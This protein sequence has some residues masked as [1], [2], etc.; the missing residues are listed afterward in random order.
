VTRVIGA[1]RRHPIF[2]PRRGPK[3][4]SVDFSLAVDL[5][6]S[7]T[8]TPGGASPDILHWQEVA[9]IPDLHDG[10]NGRLTDATWFGRQAIKAT[11]SDALDSSEGGDGSYGT[12]GN[13]NEP[14]ITEGADCWIRKQIYIPEATWTHSIIS[15]GWNT[16]LEFHEPGGIGNRSTHFGAWGSDPPVWNLSAAGGDTTSSSTHTDVWVRDDQPIEYDTWIDWLIHIHWSKDEAGYIEWWIDDR[17]VVSRTSPN[18][19]FGVEGFGITPE[20]ADDYPTAW[21]HGGVFKAPYFQVGHYRGPSKE[22]V[23]E[24]YFSDVMVGTTQESV[25]G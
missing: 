23:E 16:F 17:Q 22:D 4:G 21:D 11:V 3:Q 1:P 5:S 2:E 13:L 8:V 9:D 15:S 19:L 14:W 18:V 20:F 25:G 10:D 7:G 6:T 24:T 12:T